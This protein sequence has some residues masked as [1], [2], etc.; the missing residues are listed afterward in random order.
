MWLDRLVHGFSRSLKFVLSNN[1]YIV[2]AQIKLYSSKTMNDKHSG[3]V[4][5]ATYPNGRIELD[6]SLDQ[7]HEWNQSSLNTRGRTLSDMAET[8]PRQTYELIRRMVGSLAVDANSL[9]I[10]DKVLAVSDKDGQDATQSIARQTLINRLP[11]V[12]EHSIE[13]SLGIIQS[14]EDAQM[15]GSDGKR[16]SLV[17]IVVEP[18]DYAF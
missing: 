12:L 13:F 17:D 7:Y 16:L 14:D 15:F 8:D 18:P 10:N 2:F 9:S 5:L 1:T 4:E 6:M 3:N 11:Q